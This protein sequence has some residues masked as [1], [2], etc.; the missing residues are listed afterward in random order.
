MPI[1]RRFCSQA[2][3]VLSLLLPV[4]AAAETPAVSP[5]INAYYQGADPQRWEAIFERQGREVFDRRLEILQALQIRPGMRIADVGAG[6]GLFT[7]LFAKAVGPSGMVFAVDVSESFVA[8]IR[9]RA[10]AEGLRDVVPVVNQQTTTDLAP[11]SVDLVFVCDT[12]HHFEYPQAMLASIREALMPGG[13]LALIDYRREPGVSAP[14]ILTHVRAD[15]HTVIDEVTQAG[16]DLIG[17]PL[18]LRDNFFVRFRKGN[19]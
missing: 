14:W 12:Y 13:V 16:L 6:T 7:L 18:K 15:R 17:E 9:Q 2:L 8:S 3:I 4:L 11:A 1:A 5:E 19:P 10:S